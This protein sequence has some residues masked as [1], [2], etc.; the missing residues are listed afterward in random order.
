MKKE[1]ILYVTEEINKILN[2][3]EEQH[4][5]LITLS[6][7]DYNNKKDSEDY[8]KTLKHY[9]TINELTETI[10]KRLYKPNYIII[11]DKMLTD[12]LM[13]TSLP[14]TLPAN[15]KSV[16]IIKV[17]KKFMMLLII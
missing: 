10:Y 7:L 1:D 13:T 9:K 3:T 2:L 4:K 16:A 15:S 11:A 12:K 6:Y 14:D 8:K 17:Q 5:D